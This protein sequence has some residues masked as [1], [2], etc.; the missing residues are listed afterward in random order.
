MEFWEMYIDSFRFIVV[1]WTNDG[2]FIRILL[3][4]AIINDNENGKQSSHLN[5]CEFGTIIKSSNSNAHS[6][7]TRTDNFFT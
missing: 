5:Q 2:I 1:K 3:M 7:N 6:Q 4:N